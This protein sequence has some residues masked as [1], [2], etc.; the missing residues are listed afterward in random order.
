M[1]KRVGEEIKKM[2]TEIRDNFDLYDRMTDKRL[3]EIESS[4]LRQFRRHLAE[5]RDE[6]KAK[7][8]KSTRK[9]GWRI[10]EPGSARWRPIREAAAAPSLLSSRRHSHDQDRSPASRRA[11]SL[12]L[13]AP[14]ERRI[15]G[16]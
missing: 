1:A 15:A 13:A 12:R 14:A 2:R 7:S 3:N 6:E 16:G 8:A 5:I 9:N 10:R 4:M 11:F